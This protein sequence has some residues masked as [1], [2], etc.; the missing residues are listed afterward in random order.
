MPCQLDR[1]SEVEATVRGQLV[2]RV[3]KYECDKPYGYPHLFTRIYIS[4]SSSYIP[5]GVI[6]NAAFAFFQSL[7]HYFKA[8]VA[9]LQLVLIDVNIARW[10]KVAAV[11]RGF[12]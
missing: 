3:L 7:L 9:R 8:L 12:S 4:L 5:V 6:H 1:P 10:F 11:K 2:F